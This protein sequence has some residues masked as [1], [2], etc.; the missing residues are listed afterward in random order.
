MRLLKARED[1]GFSLTMFPVN[2]PSY[3]ILSHR[4]EADDQEVKLKDIEDR[5][6]THKTGYI[7]IEFCARQAQNDHLEHFWVAS[8][9][10][11]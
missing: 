2:P 10:I 5:V 6:G 9:C 7:K 8:C 1:G 3:A 4:R 11:D